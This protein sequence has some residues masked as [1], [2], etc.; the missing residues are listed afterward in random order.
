L[1][2]VIGQ[3]GPGAGLMVTFCED[4]ALPNILRPMGP[5]LCLVEGGIQGTNPVMGLQS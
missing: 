4:D 3:T 5:S 1:S 2:L